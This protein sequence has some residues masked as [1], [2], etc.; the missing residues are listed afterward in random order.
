MVVGVFGKPYPSHFL[1]V[2]IIISATAMRYCSHLQTIICRSSFPKLR[3][4]AGLYG[5]EL[6]W[7]KFQL[8]EVQCRAS[9]LTPTGERIEAKPGIDY[10]GSVLSH[11]GLPGHE[12]GRRVGKAKADFLQLQKV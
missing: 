3:M 5:M 7:D 11:D 1:N 8:L 4:L 9:I 12:L 6:H 10:L 2:H